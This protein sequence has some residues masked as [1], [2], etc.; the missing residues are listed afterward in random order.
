MIDKPVVAVAMSGGVD[1]SVAAALLVEQGYSVVG[2][3][4]HLWSEQVAQPANRC[5]TPD[6]IAA[7]R[8]VA[9][10]LSIPFYVLD[11]RKIFYN[12]VVNPFIDGYAHGWTP[13]PCIACNRNVRWGYL[14][15]HAMAAG[16]S[17]LATGHY[18]RLSH[19]DGH[20]FQLLCGLDLAKD[21][22]YVLHVLSQHQL[23]HALFPLGEFTKPQVRQ[24]ARQFN[25][26]VADRP[27]S[28]DLCFVGD[29]GDYRGFLLRHAPQTLL[30]GKIVDSTG[31]LL[32]NHPGL[33]NYTIGQRKGLGIASSTPLYVISKDYDKNVLIVG[34][35]RDSVSYQLEAINVN[36]ISG[37]PPETSIDASVKIR[38]KAQPLPCKVQPL[39]STTIR[40]NFIDPVRDITP[41]QAAVLYNGE[42]CLGGGIISSELGN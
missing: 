29:T 12:A 32:G 30:P 17:Y 37:L 24:R 2:M 15:D 40:L 6:S 9:A 7:A 19:F 41:G 10:L 31:K 42:V 18:A 39:S 16:A 20:P 21:Q 25:L 5:C 35:R 33:A 13:N 3:M 1:S 27:D 14:F 22:S 34:P 28:Q 23:E 26:P 11:A 4:L 38:Y 8:Q 36:W